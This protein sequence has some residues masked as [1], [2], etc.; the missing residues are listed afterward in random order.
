MQDSPD[1][2]A[3]APWARDSAGLGQAWEFAFLTSSRVLLLLAQDPH[4]ASLS[5]KAQTA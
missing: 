5:C 3:G 1:A 4:S 2:P